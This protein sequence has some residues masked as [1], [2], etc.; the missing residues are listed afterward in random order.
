MD[1]GGVV[2]LYRI[3]V[4]I[5]HEI[6]SRGKLISLCKCL[7]QTEEDGEV[8]WGETLCVTLA[9]PHYH[10]A[11]RGWKG[12]RLMFNEMVALLIS[13]NVLF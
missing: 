12:E 11:L 2:Y 4:S 7:K 10:D 9:Q 13:R 5:D 1:V 6:R 3:L 8:G